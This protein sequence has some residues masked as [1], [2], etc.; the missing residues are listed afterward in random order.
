MT[1]ENNEESAEKFAELQRI[2]TKQQAE[3]IRLRSLAQH[4]FPGLQDRLHSLE[5]RD[6][7]MLQARFSSLEQHDVPKLLV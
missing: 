2:Q 4:D 7:S 5:Q 3:I 6:F 1:E